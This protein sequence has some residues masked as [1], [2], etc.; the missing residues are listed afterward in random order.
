MKYADWVKYR[1]EVDRTIPRHYKKKNINKVEK[2]L[3][4]AILKAANK[5]VRKKKIMDNN[6]CYMSEGG[7]PEKKQ[8][9]GD[10]EGE[11]AMMDEMKRGRKEALAYGS[12]NERKAISTFALNGLADASYNS[13]TARAIEKSGLGYSSGGLAPFGGGPA[14]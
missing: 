12:L 13:P 14:Q 10:G 8:T 4:K 11:L 3:R 9:E 2:K 6:K 7:D 1:E 5:H